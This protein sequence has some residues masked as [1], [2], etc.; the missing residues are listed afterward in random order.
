MKKKGLA[1]AI[2]GVL[3]VGTLTGLVYANT[4]NN[5]EKGLSKLEVERNIFSSKSQSVEVKQNDKDKEKKDIYK[6][7][8]KIMKENGYEDMA[9]AMQNNDHEVIDGF[10]NNM[11]DEDYENM[12]KIMRES[13]YGYMADMMESIGREEMIQM[14]NDMGG[15]EN[16]HGT[17]S[18][19]SSMMGDFD[20]FRYKFK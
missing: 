1:F 6:D 5:A 7:M 9:K 4:D 17:G 3:A 14:H 10:M 2:A 18:S 12:I 8:I 13:D 19:N 11:T 20:Q 16:C 15:A